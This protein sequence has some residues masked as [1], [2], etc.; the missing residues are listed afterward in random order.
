MFVDK[1][2][3]LWRSNSRCVGSVIRCC[4]VAEAWGR[5]K[6]RMTVQT[7]RMTRKKCII[8]TGKDYNTWFNFLENRI[9]QC[10]HPNSN[11]NK[12]AKR[13]PQTKLTISLSH[14]Q[15]AQWFAASLSSSHP[16]P[17][18]SNINDNMITKDFILL[19]DYLKVTTS[20]SSRSWCNSFQI[21]T[22]DMQRRLVF[23][24]SYYL[25]KCLLMRACSHT[26]INTD[27]H[28]AEL[29][30]GQWWSETHSL[31]LYIH[32]YVNGLK[33]GDFRDKYMHVVLFR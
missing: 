28:V 31:F 13:L 18:G 3:A 27:A 15:A 7:G 16:Q 20:H 12:R 21:P 17:S 6:Q 23:T 11:V 1:G 22:A 32:I 14:T 24:F 8:L 19:L 33:L 26:L 2:V 29:N 5:T 4:L 9:G 10:A 25:W 30:V